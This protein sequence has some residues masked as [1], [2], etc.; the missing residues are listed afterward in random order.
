MD[1]LVDSDVFC[2]LGASNLL[3]PALQ[4]FQSRL[5]DSRRL[6]ALPYMLQ[7]GT[8]LDSYGGEVCARLRTVARTIPVV[9]EPSTRWIDILSSVTDVDPGE[10]QLLAKA[11]EDRLI[12][13]TGDKRALCAIRTMPELCV[14]LSGRV[15]VLEAIMISLCTDL[16]VDVVSKAI[17][18]VRHVDTALRICFS[19]ARATPVE[20]LS[21]YFEDLVRRVRPLVLWSQESGDDA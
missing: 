16:G 18:P 17:R 11:A 2:V 3:E 6:P 12:V 10:A 1:V 4:S 8:L 7:R 13:M 15:V 9:G 19:D 20:A 14:A 21:S 5:Q